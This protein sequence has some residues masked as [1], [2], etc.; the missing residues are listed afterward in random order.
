ML[1]AGSEPRER[2][3]LLNLKENMLVFVDVDGTIKIY[4][5]INNKIS[6][7]DEM[8]CWCLYFL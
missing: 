8:C 4:N 7:D 5:I 6:C 3:T 1:R 2:S